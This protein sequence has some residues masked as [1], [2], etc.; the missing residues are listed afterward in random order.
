MA[1]STWLSGYVFCYHRGIGCH[2]LG[3]GWQKSWCHYDEKCRNAINSLGA[4]ELTPAALSV[5][6]FIDYSQTIGQSICASSALGRK[7]FFFRR[8]IRDMTSSSTTYDVIIAAVES[9]FMTSSS[10]HE[11]QGKRSWTEISR[12]ITL[13]HFL[14]H[15]QYITAQNTQNNFHLIILYRPNA[16]LFTIS[17]E[18]YLSIRTV[19]HL[20]RCNKRGALGAIQRKRR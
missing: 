15:H 13:L 9:L 2:P 14:D 8:L 1:S 20:D 18:T 11:G 12:G 7:Y 3:I 4:S 6:A 5:S 19:I 16:I 17:F 10:I